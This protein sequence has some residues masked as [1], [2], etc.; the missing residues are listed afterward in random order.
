MSKHVSSASGLALSLII[1]TLPIVL[2]GCSEVSTPEAEIRALIA[3]AEIAAEA[4]DLG[5]IRPLIAETYTDRRGYNK[6]DIEGLLRLVFV[7]HQSVHLQVYVE[8]IEFVQPNIA[9][10]V[11]L[12]GIADTA[13][14]LPDV[15]LYQFDVRLIRNDDEEWQL[16]E[17]DWRR[18]LG[19]A[20]ER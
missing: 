4:R 19:K 16:V 10:A 18:G 5:D 20:P 8:T 15:D 13:G 17:A 3:K 6:P 2:T 9:N 14:A 1:G 11:A 7:A 12:V